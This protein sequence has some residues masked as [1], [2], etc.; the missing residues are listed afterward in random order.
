[1]HPSC[2]APRTISLLLLCSVDWYFTSYQ[3]IS[4]ILNENDD[5]SD[6][7]FKANLYP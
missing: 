7:V 3:Q 6:L 2:T 5:P 1:M 4:I